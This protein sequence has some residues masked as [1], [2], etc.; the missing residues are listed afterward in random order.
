MGITEQKFK[1]KA[2]VV[3]D[4]GTYHISGILIDGDNNYFY[5][6]ANLRNIGRILHYGVPEYELEPGV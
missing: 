5:D 1:F 2:I 3:F 4:S 6:L